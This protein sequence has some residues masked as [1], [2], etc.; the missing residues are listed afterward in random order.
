M[1]RNKELDDVT[2]VDI[3]VDNKDDLWLWN[4]L[5]WFY[6]PDMPERPASQDEHLKERIL[7]SVEYNDHNP[8]Y[9][10]MYNGVIEE[11]ESIKHSPETIKY[12]NEKGVTFYL[13]EPLCIYLPP[14]L[15]GGNQQS[16][17]FG[18]DKHTLTFY[19]EFNGEEDPNYLRADE[20]NSIKNYVI[21]NDLRK[22]KVKTCDYDADKYLPYYNSLM[23]VSCE[24][25]FI[26]NATVANVFDD[27]YTDD[28]VGQAANDFTK[29]FINL[30]WR[31]T[32]HRNLIAAFLA[33]SEAHI[34]F[35]Y[36]T[37]LTKLQGLPWF[38]INESEYSE[39][40]HKGVETL[41]KEPLCLDI[42][43]D[44]LLDIVET[45]YPVNSTVDD[46][47]DPST[48]FLP[49]EKYY[50]DIFCAV[51]TESRFAQ[52]TA[53]YSEKVQQPMWYR[54]PFIL[55]APPGTLKYLHEHGYKTFSDFWDESYDSCTNHEERLYKIFD[56][57]EYI[58]SKS[59]EE[60]KDI[61]K[62]ME[63]ILSHNRTQ[64]ES[65][66]YKWK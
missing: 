20:L 26:K 41:Y 64:V 59:I 21:K 18:E 27:S 29:K 66:I 16:N 3:S 4:K 24:D 36:K 10:F 63:S 34:S 58:E 33:N 1:E 57:I 56:V 47:F 13:N 25:T 9:I 54:K 23:T 40:L 12:L 2:G 44:E 38:D 52:P 42:K 35:V 32:P 43:V 28:L 14:H 17:T 49:I 53:N 62:E 60:L 50:K 15:R 39:R 37:D 51:I 65:N 61:Y 8:T 19:S 6:F 22:V 11:L 55:M 30:N 48:D 46:Y 31:W 5:H 7:P 45:P